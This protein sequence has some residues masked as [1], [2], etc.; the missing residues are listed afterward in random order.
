[1]GRRA[2]PN[3]RL[4]PPRP[5]LFPPDAPR[6]RDR[7][8][9][10]RLPEQIHSLARSLLAHHL[11]P[12]L[13]RVFSEGLDDE[14]QRI[15][16]RLPHAR[17][18]AERVLAGRTDRATLAR[19]GDTLDF[20]VSMSSRDVSRVIATLLAEL[21][22]TAQAARAGLR[23]ER[24]EQRRA[25]L[26]DLVRL[27]TP[28]RPGRTAAD[29]TVAELAYAIE[30]AYGEQLN[31]RERDELVAAIATQVLGRADVDAE[32]VRRMAARSRAEA[33]QPAR[34]ARRLSQ[35]RQALLD[36]ARVVRGRDGAL[37]IAATRLDG[38][39]VFQPLDTTDI[40]LAEVQLAAFRFGHPL[41]GA[42]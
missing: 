23:R 12:G 1:M 3:K 38:T 7:I 2:K 16:D 26:R 25:I 27:L 34:A 15:S 5:P 4:A 35:E 24:D 22:Y 21:G 9:L 18:H 19:V 36:S 32:S 41:P 42:L 40:E 13:A 28:L 29:P 31:A 11:G 30:V 37:V 6:L 14:A 20:L 17:E 10:D 8:D 33:S 39:R